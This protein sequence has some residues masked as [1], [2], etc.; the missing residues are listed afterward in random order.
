MP[1]LLEMNQKPQLIAL[2]HTKSY[3]KI[4][5]MATYLLI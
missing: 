4:I 5:I 1:K 2:E 3:D